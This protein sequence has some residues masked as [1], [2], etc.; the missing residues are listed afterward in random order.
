MLVTHGCVRLYPEHIV[1]RFPLVPV[2]TPVEFTYQPIKAGTRRGVVYVEV[3]RD[4]YKY[5]R[6]PA[7]ALKE[8]LARRRLAGRTD[9][10]L[11]DGALRTADGVPVRV[12]S[13]QL[14]RR[15]GG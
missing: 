7:T 12:S 4:I 3:H 1:R 14:A 2:G 15:P 13:E 10:R 6:S 5:S 9:R 8:A 11:V